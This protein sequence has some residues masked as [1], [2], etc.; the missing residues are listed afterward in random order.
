MSS[1]TPASAITSTSPSFWQVMPTAPA[2]HLQ[3]GQC[4]NLVR[5][6]VRAVVE[7]VARKLL[8]RALDVGLDDVEVD[9]DGGG[10]E[11]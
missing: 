10:I 7:P 11:I 1:A 4:R 2:S 8:L 6:D 3:L 5:L 9:D